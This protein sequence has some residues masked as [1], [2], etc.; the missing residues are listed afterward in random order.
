MP[1]E[2]ING[3]DLFYEDHGP[4]EGIPLVLIHGWTANMHRW[5]EQIKYFT[6]RRVIRLDLRGHGESEKRVFSDIKTLSEDLNALFNHLNI[7]KA[8]IMGH[9]MG[10]MVVIQFT[11]DYPEKVERLII[12][13][14]LGK[15][16]YSFGRKMLGLIA[17][18]LPYN[19]FLKTNINRGFSKS[20]KE[21]NPEIIEEAIKTSDKTPKTV[22]KT[23]FSKAMGTWD[24]ID[25]LGTIQVPTLIIVGSEDIQFPPSAS[26]TLNEK[27]P[28]SSLE[29][30]EGSGHEVPIEK[31]DELN[32]LIEKFI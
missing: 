6:N 10:G 19:A 26:R 21:K 1:I 24:V 5:D 9:S 8:I 17:K 25:K 12:L 27:I 13:G 20:F 22:V 18:L 16:N 3:I 15:F 28:N 14:S 31:P 11:L 4:K 32:E 23:A 7:E 29:I 30:V 2:K